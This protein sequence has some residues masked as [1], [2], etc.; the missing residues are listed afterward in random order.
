MRVMTR[1][2]QC[3][4]PS[5]GTRHLLAKEEQS[6]IKE[7][8]EE[9]G[10]AHVLDR[11]LSQLSGG[12]L[13]RV[14]L[15]TALAHP[16]ACLFVLDEP[17]SGVDIRHQQY[18]L[19]AIQKRSQAGATFVISVHD[20]NL[21]LELGD[22]FIGLFEGQQVATGTRDTFFQA[23]SMRAIFGRPGT[24]TVDQAGVPSFRF[25]QPHGPKQ[26]AA[27]SV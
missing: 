25:H 18:V 17:F 19:K 14:H 15:A 16:T 10:I 27:K 23:D 2:G 11:T 7:I 21:A 13:R 20:I 8:A 12:E 9:L 6:Q 24:M 26:G 3:F 5:R 1:M 4:L 22:Q